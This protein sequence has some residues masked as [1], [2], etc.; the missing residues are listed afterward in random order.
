[1]MAAPLIIGTDLRSASA[2]TLAILVNKEII[3]VDQDRLGVQGSVVADHD[4]LMVLDRPLAGGDHAIALYNATDALA[5]VSVPVT[6]TGLRR[7]GAY[8][9]QDLWSG[10]VL[11]ARSTINSGG[12]DHIDNIRVE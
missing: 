5:T 10:T 12:E 6:A 2:A 1:M 11:A 4:G 9:L 8:R 7:A 3:A